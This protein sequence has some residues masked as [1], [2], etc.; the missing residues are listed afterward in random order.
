MVYE[1]EHTLVRNWNTTVCLPH[2][3]RPLVEGGNAEDEQFNLKFT[4]VAKRKDEY[5]QPTAT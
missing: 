2:R 5:R 4:R 1:R 3:V